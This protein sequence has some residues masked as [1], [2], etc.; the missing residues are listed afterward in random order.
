MEK[1]Q[2]IMAQGMVPPP[3]QSMKRGDL[4]RYPVSDITGNEDEEYG[5]VISATC[6]AFRPK[7]GDRGAQILEVFTGDKIHMFFAHE[8]SVVNEA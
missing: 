6:S 4:I 3:I 1:D 5:I 8:V 2:A 7:N